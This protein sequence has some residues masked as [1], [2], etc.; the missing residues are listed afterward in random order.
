MIRR[1]A[2]LI[3]VLTAFAV[4]I[5]LAGIVLPALVAAKESAKST[6]CLNA[7]RQQ[8]LALGLYGT[9]HDDRYPAPEAIVFGRIPFDQGL[10]FSKQTIIYRDWLK[11]YGLS[12][13]CGDT[14]VERAV[15][16]MGFCLNSATSDTIVID[17]F[18]YFW[19]SGK[20]QSSFDA[21]TKTIESFECRSGLVAMSVPDDTDT[22][23]RRGPDDL[24][25][26][27]QF[28]SPKANA[29]FGGS[30][31]TFVSGSAD[32]LPTARVRA[33]RLFEP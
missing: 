21:P 7:V 17:Q 28:Q 24:S 14:P 16:H 3:E 4:I 30:N 18:D 1:G 32:W 2:S 33:E 6:A 27:W 10:Q 5:I 13:T 11:P 26:L 8:S 29:Y 12:V 23:A 22:P 19:L 15:W 31:Y 9:D 20:S 25:H